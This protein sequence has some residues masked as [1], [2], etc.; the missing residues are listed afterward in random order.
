MC[1][2]WC[3]VGLQTTV[4]M[5]ALLLPHPSFSKRHS[6]PEAVAGAEDTTSARS[7][8]GP[9]AGLHLPLATPACCESSRLNITQGRHLSEFPRI[10]SYGLF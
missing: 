10:V 5:E 7:P 2:A 3:I 8:P 9:R 4:T 6:F 1:S